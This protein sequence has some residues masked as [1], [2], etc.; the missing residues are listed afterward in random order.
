MTVAT[1]PH[2]LILY[3]TKNT[4]WIMSDD[5]LKKAKAKTTL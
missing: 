3:Y 1:F 2:L 4:D 5:S